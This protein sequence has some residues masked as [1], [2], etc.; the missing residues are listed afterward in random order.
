VLKLLAKPWFPRKLGLVCLGNQVSLRTWIHSLRKPC[1]YEETMVPWG[2]W[3]QFLGEPWFL[4]QMNIFHPYYTKK[5]IFFA[6]F[7]FNMQFFIHIMRHFIMKGWRKL[8]HNMDEKLYNVWMLKTNDAIVEWKVATPPPSQGIFC[9]LC[10]MRV[11][12]VINICS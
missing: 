2:K 7:S 9:T 1:F 4:G 3:V 6:K 5:I 8:L 10:I 12:E 11:L